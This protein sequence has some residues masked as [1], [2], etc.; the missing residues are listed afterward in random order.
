MMDA[1]N[2]PYRGTDTR[3]QGGAYPDPARVFGPETER[4]A[5][6]RQKRQSAADLLPSVTLP[7]GGGAVRGIGEKFSII[8]AD[9]LAA[10]RFPAPWALDDQVS[11]QNRDWLTT[12]VEKR[13]RTGSAG[14][15]PIRRSPGR[16]TK[17]CRVIV[18]A[19]SRMFKYLPLPKML[20]RSC[21]RLAHVACGGATSMA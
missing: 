4:P 14:V 13:A 18:T 10:C 21:T 5:S 12:P 11:G 20:V 6:D 3:Q 16:P 9:A 15:L 7:K 19:P 2:A 1:R 8:A 17:A